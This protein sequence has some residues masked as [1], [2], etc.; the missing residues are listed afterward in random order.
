MDDENDL[1]PRIVV[2]RKAKEYVET[3][4]EEE[5][6]VPELISNDIDDV[7]ED[8]I[9]PPKVI[10]DLPVSRKKKEIFQGVEEDEVVVEKPK[11]VRKARKPP[12][13]HQLDH[14]AK[15]RVKAQDAKKKKQLE[16]QQAIKEGKPVSNVKPQ[17]VKYIENKITDEDVDRL[18][19]RYKTR[20]K[21]KKDAKKADEH[22]RQVVQSHY[23]PTEQPQP[24][25]KSFS[26]FF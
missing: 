18:I 9:A 12:S 22:A 2:D 15:I 19:D 3:D 14:L 16:R 23:T 7:V 20:K 11:P 24:I 8:E 5:E 1:M 13:Q 21:V 4:E 26:D 10:K 25:H 17:K 6:V